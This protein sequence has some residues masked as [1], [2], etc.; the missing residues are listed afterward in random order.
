MV[1]SLL[2]PR[3]TSLGIFKDVLSVSELQREM[4]GGRTHKYLPDA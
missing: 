1:Y 2:R 4:K 3:E